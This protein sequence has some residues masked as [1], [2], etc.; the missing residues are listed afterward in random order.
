MSNIIL[1]YVGRFLILVFVQILIF[2]QMR[3]SGYISPYIYIIFILALPLGVSKTVLLFSSF[4]LGLS[5][6]LFSDSLGMH[7]A[8]SVFMAFCRP[9]IINAIS[10]KTDFEEGLTPSLAN[11]GI[12]WLI[13]YTVILVFLHHTF[14]FFVEI[15]SFAEFWSTIAKSLMSTV[16]TF[17]IIIIIHYLFDK[18]A[19]K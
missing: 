2:D 5:I 3:F 9:F 6:D 18:I 17:S 12:R 13:P 4:A 11:M 8:A 15:F 16:L 10:I 19:K 14:L 7:A 1:K